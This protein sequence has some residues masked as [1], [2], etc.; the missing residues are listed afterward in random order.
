M[1]LDSGDIV[2]AYLEQQGGKPVIRISAEPLA[3]VSVSIDLSTW[4][5]LVLCPEP[6]TNSASRV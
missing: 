2:E 5:D 6:S 4:H 1:E 3:D